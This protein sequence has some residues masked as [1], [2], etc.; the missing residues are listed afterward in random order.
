MHYHFLAHPMKMC[1]HGLFPL[2]YRWFLD[3][4]QWA[5]LQTRRE[6]SEI[7]LAWYDGTTVAQKRPLHLEVIRQVYTV[8]STVWSSL[9]CTL[10]ST[11]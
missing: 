11:L 1:H 9:D 10:N 5:F 2:P 8:T 6:G 3:T 7:W 4:V